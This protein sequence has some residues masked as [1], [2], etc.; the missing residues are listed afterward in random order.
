MNV[1]T[2]MIQGTASSA[3]KSALVTGLCRI[4]ARR[5]VRVAPFKAQNMALNSFITA[6]GGEMGRSQAIQAEA[7]GVAPCAAMNPVLLKPTSDRKS[8]V[9]VDG[10]PQ[11]IMDAKEFY[12]YRHSLKPVVLDAFASLAARCDMIV[13]EGAGSPAEI[14]LRENDLV[15]MGMALSV[16]APVVLVGDIDRG[17]VFASIYGTAALLEPE[18]RALVKGFVVNKFRGDESILTP[19]VRRLEEM[20]RIPSLGVLPYWDLKLEEEDSL[21]RRLDEYA[22]RSA[23]TVDIVVIKLPR[24]ANFTDFAPF[25][26]LPDVRLRYAAP[27][28]NF[29]GPDLVVLPDS[30]NIDEALRALRDSG[31]AAA[32]AEHVAAG[33]ILFG[34][35]GGC[36]M[37]GTRI[38]GEGD[39]PETVGLGLLDVETQWTAQRVAGQAKGTIQAVP[40]VFAAMRG[41]RTEGYETRSSRIVPGASATPLL[42]L[43]DGRC[44]GAASADGAVL[45][46][47][48]HGLFDEI[49]LIRA[50][51]DALR[52][53]RGLAPCGDMP[54]FATYKEHRLALYDKLADVIEKHLAMDML[55]AIVAKGG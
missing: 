17:G 44:A 52:R 7:C 50:L 10:R 35:G 37:L 24:L 34:V 55:D 23:E 39:E 51:A 31:T 5:G 1:K 40:G 46:A 13:L 49:S 11:T 36:R 25:D 42:L 3:G 20:L 9:V 33:G 47:C 15:N 4:Y 22:P 38:A 18:E 19:G 32:L 12:A 14:N 54:L 29:G 53:R 26:L 41:F 28:E 30:Q 21:A 45:G 6:D 16:N 43:E 8:R 27:G 48:P 2:L